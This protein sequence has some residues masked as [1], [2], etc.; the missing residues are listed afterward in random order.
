MSAFVL[1]SAGS[2]NVTRTDRPSLETVL[3]R[4]AAWSGL[5]MSVTPLILPRRLTTSL[6]AAVTSGSPDL[7]EPLP[8]MSTRS[9]T[10]CGKP[11]SSTIMAPRLESPLPDAESLSWTW[12]TLPP[13]SVAS[14]TNAIHPR[15]AV[16]RCCALHLPARAARFLGCKSPSPM[17]WLSTGHN[18]SSH[19]TPAQGG[20]QASRR[21]GPVR[22]P[23]AGAPLTEAART[24]LRALLRMLVVGREGHVRRRGDGL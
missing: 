14:T 1:V 19:A 4:S 12:P 15:I 2:A 20:L 10:C 22:S 18:R 16:F 13:T 21:G 8:W 6:T 9:P 5:W 7:I 17:G 24:G 23:G 11:A 3:A